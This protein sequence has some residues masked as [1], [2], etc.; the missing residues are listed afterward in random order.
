MLCDGLET[1]DDLVIANKYDSFF[2]NI[3]E[4]QESQFLP[5]NNNP[6]HYIDVNIPNSLFVQPVTLAE[7]NKIIVRLKITSFGQNSLPVKIG[8]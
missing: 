5:A 2:A 7:C 1:V 3:A 6:L 8:I 4:D